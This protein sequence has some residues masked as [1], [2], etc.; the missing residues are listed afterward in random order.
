MSVSGAAEPPKPEKRDHRIEQNG[1]MRNDPFFWL[2]D[3]KDPAVIRYLKAENGYTEEALRP[4]A[5]LQETLYREMRGR[6]QEADLSVP[7]KIGDYFYYTRTREGDQYPIHCRKKGNLDAPEEVILDEND[8][9]KGHTYFRVGVFEV[10]TNHQLLAYSADTD[11]GESYTLRIKDLKT[12]K[13]LPE[14]IGNTSYSFAWANDNQTFFYDQLDAAK[15]PYR[16]MRHRLGA[17][18]AGDPL[19]YEEKDERFFLGIEKSRSEKFIFVDLSSKTSSEVRYLNA[20]EPE[21]DFKMIRP[22]EEN[23]RYSVDHRA[24]Q[25]FIVT[26]DQAKNFKV[27][28]APVESPGKENWTDFLPYDP[29]TKVEQAEA[30]E[31]HLVILERRKGLPTIRVVDLLRHES[32]DVAFEEPTFGLGLNDNPE[33]RTSIVRFTYSSLLTPRSV[34]DYDLVSRAKVLKKETPVRGGYDKARYVSERIFARADDGA[35]IPISL[36]YR[37]GFIRDSTAPL[38][39]TGYGAYG[40]SQDATFNSNCLSLVDRGFVF[41]IAHVRGG[42]ELGETWYE[43]GKLLRKKNTFSDF[44]RCAEHLLEQKYASPKRVAVLGGSAGGLLMGAVMNMRPDLFTTV[45]AAVPFVDVLN[46]MSDPSLPLTVAEYEEWGNPANPEFYSYIASY[47]PY[48]SIDDKTYPNL[49]VTGGLNDPRV[50]YWEPAKWVAK[51][52]W[53][54]NQSGRRLLLKTNLL[55]GHGGDSGRFDRLKEIALEYAFVI[56]TLGMTADE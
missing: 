35:E 25:F 11:G 53:L 16:L 8:L 2:R 55:A 15:R 36:F 7:E 28:T 33:F 6:I 37:Q 54:K 56:D 22:R 50:S 5:K 32:H 47:S 30:F 31:N 38:F 20:D 46:T 29:A 26:D 9:A 4:T 14:T 40:Y 52:R 45:V 13:L 12:G 34:F 1:Q 41:A 39:L 18:P 3:R 21:S 27:V 19:L 17:D 48:D 44:I 42:G 23:I 51:Q 10:S 49:L 24:D 43:E